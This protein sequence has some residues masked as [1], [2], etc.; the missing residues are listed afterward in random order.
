MPARELRAGIGNTPTAVEAM[1]DLGAAI[2]VPAFSVKRDDRT[3]GAPTSPIP[4]SRQRYGR[5][6][7]A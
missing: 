6:S 7:A 2:G 1:P 4:S 5:R 3:G